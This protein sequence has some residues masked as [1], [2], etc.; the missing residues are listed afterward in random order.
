MLY[1]AMCQLKV[2]RT[3]FRISK[4]VSYIDVEW[5][6]Y[7]DE[8]P[9]HS[10]DPVKQAL[11]ESLD[12]IGEATYQF[13]DG[14]GAYIAIGKRVGTIYEYN[15][16]A[17]NAAAPAG[18]NAIPLTELQELA[19]KGDGLLMEDFE[20]YNGTDIGS[21]L[22]ILQFTVEG[23]YTVLSSA[24]GDYINAHQRE[25]DAILD[26]GIAALPALTSILNI[27]DASLRGN[28]AALAVTDIILQ[29][30]KFLA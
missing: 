26:M 18:R 19:A 17:W 15:G 3:I 21:G 10:K 11:N 4:T 9:H 22:Y 6:E 8:F 16:V 1:F 23:G 2:E 20:K 27:G 29:S 5:W 25:Y 13:T 7:A 14:H 30:K 12:A 28:I 24:T